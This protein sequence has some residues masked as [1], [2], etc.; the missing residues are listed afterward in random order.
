MAG[1][2]TVLGVPVPRP[3]DDASQRDLSQELPRELVSRFGGDGRREEHGEG[4]IVHASTRHSSAKST[5]RLTA[6]SRREGLTYK[7]APKERGNE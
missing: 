1:I 3:D 5:T 6:L 2:V 7:I 4:R